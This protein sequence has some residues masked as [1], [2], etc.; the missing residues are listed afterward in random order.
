M[1][2]RW[3]ID[4]VHALA[5]DASS[6][7]AVRKISVP[8]AWPHAGLLPGGALVVWGECRGSGSRS[9][10]VTHKDVV[11]AVDRSGS[12]AESVVYP[13]E[14]LFG[15][16][17]GGGT[18]INRAISYCQGLITRPTE[19]TF[20]LFSSWCEGGVR[21]QMLRR[22][23]Q[24]KAAG[25]QV[26]VLLALSDEGAPFYDHGNA[27]AL[28]DLGVPA[29]VCTPDAFPEIMAASLRGDPI[30]APAETRVRAGRRAA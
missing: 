21:E 8:G 30:T 22:V 15:T 14:V 16:Q 12:M 25:T 1:S 11:L 18:D 2:D 29:Y 13:V 10:A 5:P 19:S 28:A 26:V 7:K 17:L 6:W 23:A 4:D 9:Y 24:M 3:S 20:V 27:V